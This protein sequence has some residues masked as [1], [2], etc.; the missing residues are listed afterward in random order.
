[1]YIDRLDGVV[2]EYNST[3]HKAVKMK[4]AD[5]KM[6][7]YTNFNV[8]NGKNSKFKVGNHVRISKYKIIFANGYTP[9]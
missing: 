9:D 1:M 7:I 8:E 3:Y 4:L 2:N 6:D 5:V